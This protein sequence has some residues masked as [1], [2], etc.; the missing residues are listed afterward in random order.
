MVEHITS[1]RLYGAIYDGSCVW[2]SVTGGKKRAC[3]EKKDG[4]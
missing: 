3:K 2:F 4:R 1:M